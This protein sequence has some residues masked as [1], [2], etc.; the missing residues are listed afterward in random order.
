MRK[1][2]FCTTSSSC[3]SVL[4]RRHLSIRQFSFGQKRDAYESQKGLCP[5]CKN[6]F[7]IGEMQADHTTPWS[8]AGRTIPSNYKMLCKDDNSRKSNV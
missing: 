8:L 7:E 4:A 5:V 6:H 1:T 3:T 2:R